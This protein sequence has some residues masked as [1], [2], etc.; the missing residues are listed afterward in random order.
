MA[1]VPDRRLELQAATVVPDEEEYAVGDTAEIFVSSPFGLAHG[2]LTTSRNGIV[3]TRPF[4]ITGTDT[5][6]EIP[7]TEGG[8]PSLT[9]DVELVGVTDRAAD[10]GTVLPGVPKRP[11][12]PAA[13]VTLRIPPA[14]RT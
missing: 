12:S 14:S 8:V 11:P 1:T 6:I 9:V 10:D 7:I 2:L 13:R 3:E 4:V 5:V